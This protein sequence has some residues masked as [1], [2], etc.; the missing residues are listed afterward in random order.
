MKYDF[1]VLGAGV[2]GMTTATILGKH[3]YRVA[4]VEKSKKIAPLLRGFWRSGVHFDT[5]FH[6]TGGLGSGE[7]LDT[8]FRYLGISNQIEKVPFD[9]EGFDIFRIVSLGSEFRFP[10]GYRRI[11]DKL[12][13]QFPEEKDAIK[14][15]LEAVE[16]TFDSSPF[17]NLDQRFHMDSALQKFQGPSL[18]TF[19]N[20]LTQNELLQ[21]ILSMHCLLY[22]VSPEEVSFTN[23]ALIVGSYYKS[24]CGI[25]GGGWSIVRAF[26]AELNKIGIDIYCGHGVK[27][28][29]FSSAGSVLGVELENKEILESNHCITTL[30]PQILLQIVPDHLFRPV[31]KKRLRTFEET[32]SA[33]MLFGLCEP[34]IEILKKRNFF[35]CP[36]T[37]CVSF[38]DKSNDFLS[39]PIYIASGHNVHNKCTKQAVIVITPGYMEQVAKW[40]ETFIGNRTSDYCLFKNKMMQI[41]QNYLASVCPELGQKINYID[42]AT[43]LTLRDYTNTPFGSLYGIKHKIG[44]YNPMPVTKLKGLF[45]A[46]QAIVAPG[47]LGAMV[48]SFLVCGLILGHNHLRSELKKCR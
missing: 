12:C 24:V 31:Y 7:I 43:P 2:S 32:P 33:F 28:V 35:I 16:E 25:K 46:G 11:Q 15:Y 10:Y 39:F 26:E 45:L 47:V 36:N 6:Y 5:G 22:G 23:H 13:E 20:Q 8:Y 21:S 41:I 3:G 38:F 9:P 30:H 27:R 44:Q 40:K 37:D 34:P 18:A 14:R 48:S 17:L 42:S 4:L 29:L 19:L 1:I